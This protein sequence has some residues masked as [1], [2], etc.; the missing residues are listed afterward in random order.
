M[1]Q[2]SFFIHKYRPIKP[3]EYIFNK[4][5]VQDLINFGERGLLPNIIFYGPQGSGKLSVVLSFLAKMFSTNNELNMSI[6]N[7]KN[8]S[9]NFEYKEKENM[10]INIIK[11][12]Y[13]FEI[14][15]E[16]YGY[17]DKKILYS[18]IADISNSIDISHKRYKIIIIKNA[19]K[20][21]LESQYTL[22]RII[23]T[24]S[25]SIR[26]ILLIQQSS[27]I[28]IAIKSRCLMIRIPGPTEKDMYNLLDNI[29]K[30]EDINI[31]QNQKE[32][33]V[34][35]SDLNVSKLLFHIEYSFSNNIFQ[36][37]I[38][39]VGTFIDNF[40]NEIK[41]I[42]CSDIDSIRN[43]IY[44]ILLHNNDI[45][46][47]YN[48][49]TDKITK[50]IQDKDII[51]KILMAAVYYNENCQIGYRNIYHLE[52][53]IIYIINLLNGNEIELIEDIL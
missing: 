9:Y 7:R 17:N 14:D 48:I 42:D 46:E 25:Q 20:L 33:L 38:D 3:E 44:I 13:Y 27:L 4:Q 2:S 51:K 26:L 11:N 19:D 31:K 32:K 34:N 30:K 53:Y 52:C 36:E 28:D 47:L 18:F 49:I 6:Y 23:E 12:N 41:N 24:K 10:E 45:Q 16:D 22:K 15:A 29:A 43:K 35:I 39:R 40:I 21:S 8:F 5:I 37:P 50:D 1:E